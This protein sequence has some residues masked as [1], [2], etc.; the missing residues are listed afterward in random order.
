M[1]KPLD[2]GVTAHRSCRERQGWSR[3]RRILRSTGWMPTG[4]PTPRI[5]RRT[6]C[7]CAR[8]DFSAERAGRSVD[9]RARSL[10]HF[11]TS[12]SGFTGYRHQDA[13][14]AGMKGWYRIE[15][16]PDFARIE[17]LARGARQARVLASDPS[18]NPLT[19]EVGA[20]DGTAG[21]HVEPLGK[22]I[23]FAAPIRLRFRRVRWRGAVEALPS[24]W[25]DM[26]G[27][28]GSLPAIEVGPREVRG[29]D[30][31]RSPFNRARRAL[32]IDDPP[33]SVRGGRSR[34][35]RRRLRRGASRGNARP[36]DRRPRDDEQA[37]R[38]E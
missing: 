14:T 4:Q 37:H 19:G 34:K 26:G 9:S 2:G 29:A 11:A 5:E 10:V 1:R 25:K 24:S 23:E 21:E 7:A 6:G 36:H 16:S 13:A 35:G 12:A 27:G 8:G 22:Q 3:S 38:R 17:G 31:H 30:C 18:S 33:W 28:K 32:Q 15:V 20:H